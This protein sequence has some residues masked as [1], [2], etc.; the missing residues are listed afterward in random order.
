MK[1]ALSLTQPWASLIA[2]GAKHIE[3]RPRRTSHRGP[4]LIHASATRTAAARAACEVPEIA[5]FLAEH[6][7][8]Y[9]TLPR[10]VILCSCR[11]T[12]CAKM[13]DVA[14][15]PPA[16]PRKRPRPAE[17]VIGEVSA[18]ERALGGYAA[19]R[20]ALL[21]ADVQLL[22]E[23]VEA[24]G[25]LSMWDATGAL[26]VHAAALAMRPVTRDYPVEIL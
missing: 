21:L 3:T 7:L 17:L 16:K 10:G 24:K 2:L 1:K 4:L 19:G 6:G 8:T 11:L 15:P 13:V 22:P 18:Q 14:T 5:A 20:F 9:D 25:A 26:A 23:P 12:E